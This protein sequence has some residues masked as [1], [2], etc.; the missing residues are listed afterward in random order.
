M[1]D[2]GLAWTSSSSPLNAPTDL[3]QSSY[4]WLDLHPLL[5]ALLLEPALPLSAG[6]WETFNVVLGTILFVLLILI[7]FDSN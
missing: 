6:V 3:Y 2:S 4:P 1:I 5:V 7:G